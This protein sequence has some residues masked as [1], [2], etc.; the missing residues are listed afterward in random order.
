MSPFGF[1][2]RRQDEAP[3]TLHQTI[4]I[5]RLRFRNMTLSDSMQCYSRSSVTSLQC[6]LVFIRYWPGH[7][8][9]LHSLF[10]GNLLLHHN[11]FS[12][13][14]VVAVYAAANYVASSVQNRVLIKS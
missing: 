9:L 6:T 13:C 7:L 10:I 5:T 8:S 1:A 4:A 11:I 2:F 12:F 3:S 14:R